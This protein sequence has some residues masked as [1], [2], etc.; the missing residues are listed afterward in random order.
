MIF[1][2]LPSHATLS[3]NSGRGKGSLLSGPFVVFVCH[4]MTGVVLA[5]DLPVTFTE[6]AAL[7]PIA[8]LTVMV[9]LPM[10]TEVTTNVFA[11]V[12]CATV[13]TVGLELVAVQALADF[14]VTVIVCIEPSV[15]NVRF[16]GATEIVL[17][18]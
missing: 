11:G 7:F 3:G 12:P 4:G 1:L 18:M 16:L 9:H 5:T 17:M 13:A 14:S 2:L 15:V 6:A 10:A 8:S